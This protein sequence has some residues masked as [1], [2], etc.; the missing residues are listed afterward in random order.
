MNHNQDFQE[1]TLS[2]TPHQGTRLKGPIPTSV[3]PIHASRDEYEI[4]NPKTKNKKEGSILAPSYMD[5][6]NFD[7]KRNIHMKIRIKN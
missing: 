3:F 5:K 6:N 4:T 7:G 2:K 1:T